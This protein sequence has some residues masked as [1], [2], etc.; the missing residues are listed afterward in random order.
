MNKCRLGLWK[1]DLRGCLQRLSRA[2]PSAGLSAFWARFLGNPAENGAFMFLVLLAV[3]GPSARLANAGLGASDVV[4]VVNGGSLNSRTLANHFVALRNIPA[5][6]VVVL[7]DVPNSETIH[8]SIFRKKILNPLLQEL[9]RRKISPHVQCVAYSADFPTAIGVE[10]DFKGRDLNRVLT[11][12]ASINGLTF[13]YSQVNDTEFPNYIGLSQNYYARQS[14]SAQLKFIPGIATLE[15]WKSIED[16]IETQDFLGA[17][18]DLEQLFARNPHLYPLAYRAAANYAAA[19]QKERALDLLQQ[20]IN[21]GWSSAKFLEADERFAP[22]DD[23]V[24]FQT[25]LLALESSTDDGVHVPPAGFDAHVRWTQCGTPVNDRDIAKWRNQVGGGYQPITSRFLLSTVLGVTRGGGTKLSDAIAAIQ[26]SAGADFSHPAGGFYF[27][28]TADIRSRTREPGFANAI[29]QLRELGYK[30]ERVRSNFAG[31]QQDV[32]GMQL[33]TAKFDWQAEGST[34]LPGAIADNLTSFGGVMKHAVGQTRLSELIKAG[35]AASS[36]TVTE[37]YSIQPKFPTPMLYPYYAQGASLAEAFYL[38]IS[39]PYQLLIVG[40]PLCRPFSNAPA[41]ELDGRMRLLSDPDDSVVDLAPQ[42]LSYEAWLDA[43]GTKAEKPQP[44]HAAMLS[45][46]VDGSALRKIGTPDQLDLAK[47]L[48]KESPGFHEVTLRGAAGD[49][50]R[51]RRDYTI[52]VWIGPKET[53]RLAASLSSSKPNEQAAT[54]NS[55]TMTWEDASQTS[56]ETPFQVSLQEKAIAL[57]L[58]ANEASK[59]TLWHDAEALDTTQEAESQIFLDLSRIG[60]GPARLTITAEIDG[61]EIRSL[62][63]WIEVQP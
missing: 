27:C 38:S 26:K 2:L 34:F 37:P 44:I 1:Y 19:S 8:V 6:N 4:V 31:D 24:A 56:R 18:K 22:L 41:F 16:K 61:Q 13:L 21:A 25:L 43:P 40:D 15:T 60:L 59:I 49:P 48:A 23:E 54:D 30:A 63:L 9:D 28:H 39:G 10:S 53:V 55:S 45:V 50:F 51:Q 20:A 5:Q 11:K 57:R 62:P 14:I 58:S 32:M 46:L 12:V 17:A 7:N 47:L 29:L 33:G 36:G 42:G 35:A 52:P 3:L